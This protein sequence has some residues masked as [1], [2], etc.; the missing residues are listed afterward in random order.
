MLID[1]NLEMDECDESKGEKQHASNWIIRYAIDEKKAVFDDD[2]LF[3]EH[4]ATR[5][6]SYLGKAAQVIRS[7][8]LASDHVIRIRPFDIA[9]D[10]DQSVAM[11][12]RD[13]SSFILNDIV[14]RGFPEITKVSY[15][16][17]ADECKTN[18]FDPSTGKL[19]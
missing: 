9:D 8:D 14:L 5:I 13:M 10:D 1:F 16:T 6:H 2:F 7:E 4:V 11:F 18:I 12:L 19:I 15:T 17:L 3:T